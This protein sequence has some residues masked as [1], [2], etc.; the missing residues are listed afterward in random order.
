GNQDFVVNWKNDGEE[1]RGFVDNKGKQRSVVR[2]PSYYFKSSVS[3]SDVTSGIAGFRYFPKGFI[4][5]V[6]GMSAFKGNYELQDILCFSNLT[7]INW[8]AKVINPTL[9]FQIGNFNQL[10]F[11]ENISSSNV[12]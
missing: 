8:V 4:F 11:T 5:D 7:F 9:H 1:I 3:W 6:T 12:D 10:P 2:N